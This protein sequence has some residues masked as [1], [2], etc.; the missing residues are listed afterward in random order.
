MVRCLLGRLP[1]GQYGLGMFDTYGQTLLTPEGFGPSWA[2]LIQSGILNNMFQAATPGALP[3]GASRTDPTGETALL[4]FWTAW[5]SSGSSYGTNS[6]SATVIHDT[7]WP[8]TNY[9]Q[10]AFTAT[11]SATSNNV[12][13]TTDMFPILPAFAYQFDVIRS[14]YV[15]AGVTLNRTSSILWYD[16][17]G[18]YISTSVTT[19][20]AT[21]GP[22]SVGMSDS[23]GSA[24]MAPGNA[25]NA[26]LE[27]N[28]WETVAHSA[29]TWFDV[30]SFALT[31][32]G[33]GYA[34]IYYNITAGG[35][36]NAG[37]A[38]FDGGGAGGTT[39]GLHL[40]DTTGASLH[41]IYFGGDTGLWR[42]LAGVLAFS[43]GTAYTGTGATIYPAQLTG[44]T[45]DWNPTGLAG[46]HA[47]IINSNAAVNLTGIVAQAD[48]RE[49]Q[50]INNGAFTITLKHDATSTAANRFYCQ[51]SADF[52]L[53]PNMTA[54][55]RY[56]GNASRW[57][58]K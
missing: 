25:R 37:D 55:L 35:S 7:T 58:V 9:V 1:N 13:L 48:G 6:A 2:A 21:A 46:C 28:L 50:L 8:G 16:G 40:G 11:G 38:F 17:T 44:N 45:N 57:R 10:L 26:R 31:C 3:L 53:S 4:P 43:G 47:I 29:S 27:I 24:V 23:G 30:G 54:L 49:Y 18:T 56:D 22:Y 19:P 12:A 51:N 14:G 42:L 32:G 33:N 15:P 52:A 39:G 5:A 36:I 41:G 34:T 20:G